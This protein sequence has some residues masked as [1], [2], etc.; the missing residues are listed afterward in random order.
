MQITIWVFPK[1]SENSGTPKSSI[2]IGFSIINHPCWGTPIFRNTH[3]GKDRSQPM[4]YQQVWFHEAG[5]P[6]KRD[7]CPNGE[8]HPGWIFGVFPSRA[9][10]LGGCLGQSTQ[11]LPIFRAKTEHPDGTQ[12]MLSSQHDS[13]RSLMVNSLEE[14]SES[15]RLELRTSRS[16]T[17][18]RL[19]E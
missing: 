6:Q 15:I 11:F 5:T 17:F 16:L 1:I 19:T 13:S 4:S 2:L 9:P 7:H 12:R 18:V 3:L 8:G 10:F 14:K